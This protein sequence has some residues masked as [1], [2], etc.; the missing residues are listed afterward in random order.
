[1]VREALLCEV[2]RV[3]LPFIFQLPKI[4]EAAR[5]ESS[6]G[7]TDLGRQQTAIHARQGR[8][9]SRQIGFAMHAHREEHRCSSS[10]N[11]L[12]RK[13]HC[14]TERLSVNCCRGVVPNVVDQRC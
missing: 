9:G 1:M 2:N 7:W 3:Y 13:S 10:N 12:G 4:P 6:L 11:K 14:P 5:P 8:G